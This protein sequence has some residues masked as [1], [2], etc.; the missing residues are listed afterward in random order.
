M[1]NTFLDCFKVLL[2]QYND[3]S[4]ARHITLALGDYETIE[5]VEDETFLELLEQYISALELGDS[6][7]LNNFEDCDGDE[8]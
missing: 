2:E 1:T 7:H 8:Y 3:T 4:L 5:F 6:I